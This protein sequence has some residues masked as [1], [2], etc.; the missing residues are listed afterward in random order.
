MPKSDI[1][2]ARTVLSVADETPTVRTL[3]F[4]DAAL[5]RA[6]PG[7]F[8]MVWVPGAGELPMS[9]MVSDI[10]GRAAFTVRT[11]GPSSRA[12]YGVREGGIIGVRGPYGNS[13]DAKADSALLVGGGTGLVPLMRLITRLPAGARIGLA[14]GSRTADEVLFEG[15]AR[16]LAKGR[17]IRIEV[18]TDDGS[19]GVAGTAV[20]AARLLLDSGRYA[21]AY[22]CGPEPMMAA[23][24]GEAAARGVPAQAS[25]ERVMKCGVGICGS[26]CMDDRLVCCDGTVFG[27]DY[28]ASS[29]D[30]GR[31]WRSK[32]GAAVPF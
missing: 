7:Q 2:S 14:M 4:E 17:E 8:A 16:A 19:R 1:P 12:L 5:A 23:L 31:A 18:A 32:S 15:R 30:F 6:E 10:A 24:V 27:G 28:L 9:V 26:C 25:V 22:T 11:H 3:E 21:A 29:A 20:D 13:F